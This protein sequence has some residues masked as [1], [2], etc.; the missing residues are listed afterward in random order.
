MQQYIFIL[1]NTLLKL[2]LHVSTLKYTIMLIFVFNVLSI[3]HVRICLAYMHILIMCI[4]E[5][6]MLQIM[7]I[8]EKIKVCM[9][10]RIYAY[11]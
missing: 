8:F 7:C 5:K 10:M 6:S 4:H 3:K 9:G 2:K 1:L 11:S